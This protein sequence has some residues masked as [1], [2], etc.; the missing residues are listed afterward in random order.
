MV[1]KAAA[2]RF[3]FGA[4]SDRRDACGGVVPEGQFAGRVVTWLEGRHSRRV[5]NQDEL[6]RRAAMSR[7]IPNGDEG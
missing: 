1:L 6:L 3:E 4:G 5:R 7:P 2:K